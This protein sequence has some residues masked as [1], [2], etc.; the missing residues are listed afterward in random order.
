[1]IKIT[2][3]YYVD[4]DKYNY[5]LLE[6]H[7]VTKSEAENSKN[8]NMGDIE[9]KTL[10]YYISLEQLLISLW[11]KHKRSISK[12]IDLQEYVDKLEKMQNTFLAKLRK[13]LR[14][15]EAE[16]RVWEERYFTITDDVKCDMC[17]IIRWEK[18]S[19]FFDNRNYYCYYKCVYR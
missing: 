6:K 9:Y 19:Y 17:N 16:E 12:E 5:I 7:I 14:E 10:G 8:K 11:E 18:A 13:G 15:Q 1:M 3:K 4:T 2:E